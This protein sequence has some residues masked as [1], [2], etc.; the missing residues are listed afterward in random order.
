MNPPSSKNGL[1]PTRTDTHA[2]DPNSSVSQ[3]NWFALVLSD[4]ITSV[5]LI[6]KWTPSGVVQTNVAIAPLPMGWPSPG[7]LAGRR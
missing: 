7:P 5:R 1:P 6:R 3:P 4:P 2:T